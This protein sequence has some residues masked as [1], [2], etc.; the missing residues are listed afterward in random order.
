MRKRFRNVVRFNQGEVW[1][2]VFKGGGR[3]QVKADSGIPWGRGRRRGREPKKWGNETP[4]GKGQGRN[5]EK[6]KKKRTR[7]SGKELWGGEKL[8]QN[9]E[10]KGDI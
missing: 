3:G 10:K 7:R 8:S 1:K 9:S 5:R 4:Q 6:F 2:G